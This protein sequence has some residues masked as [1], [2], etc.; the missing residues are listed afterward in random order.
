[1][2]SIMLRRSCN[3]GGALQGAP[4]G[5]YFYC[6]VI[7]CLVSVPKEILQILYLIRYNPEMV[8]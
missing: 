8:A 7:L 2:V 1:M 5:F 6:V 4:P 3:P